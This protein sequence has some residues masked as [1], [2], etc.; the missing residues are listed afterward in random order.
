MIYVFGSCN[1][2][3][4]MKVTHHPQPGET[5]LSQ[6]YRLYAGGKGANQAVAVAR[7]HGPVALVGAVGSDHFAPFLLNSM[8]EDHENYDLDLSHVIRVDAPTGCAVIA[9]DP[10]GEN[11]IIVSGG[12]N[13]RLQAQHFPLYL[14]QEGDWLILQMEVSLEESWKLASQAKERG[15]HVI[16][17]AGP[18]LHIPLEVM[19]LLDTLIVNA[20]E[21]SILAPHAPQFL[22]EPESLGKWAA[23][24]F[25]MHVIMTLGAKG[26]FMANPLGQTLHLPAHPVQVVDTVAAGDTFVGYL[27]AG[28]HGGKSMVDALHM[29]LIASAL[30]CTKH[31]AQASIPCLEEVMQAMG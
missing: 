15:A 19:P 9:I 31:G 16:L 13:L 5:L 6:E 4:V 1:V 8:G 30:A 21:I 10:A 26:A 2:D 18:A 29:S 24:A 25:N 23:Q 27:A 7:A 11:T 20:H 17:N 14:L 22:K 12:A 28:L 3:M